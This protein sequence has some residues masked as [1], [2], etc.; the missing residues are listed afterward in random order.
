MIV[1]RGY[2]KGREVWAVQKTYGSE[3]VIFEVQ[4]IQ[5]VKTRYDRQKKIFNKFR[6]TKRRC[7]WNFICKWW[8][9]KYL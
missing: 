2:D 9:N 4:P 5:G 3:K 8:R 6:K 1:L 7:C